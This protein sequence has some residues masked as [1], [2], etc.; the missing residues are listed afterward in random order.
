MN[1]DKPIDFVKGLLRR[2]RYSFTRA[3]A[4]AAVGQ[5]GARLSQTLK[6]LSDQGWVKSFSRG[7]YCAL[8]VQHQGSGLL[9]PKWFID[10]W[11]RF[12]GAEY[13]V[14]ALS[15]AALHGAAHQRPITFQVMANQRLRS[16]KHPGLWPNQK[17]LRRHGSGLQV[18]ILYK[19]H[20]DPG[21]WT[22][23]KS[24]AGY[25]HVSTPEMTAYDVVAY[26]RACPSLDQ[27]ATVMVELGE[28]MRKSK[29][30]A[31]GRPECGTA[32]LQ[33]LGWLLERS[34]WKEKAEG[35]GLAL[36]GRQLAWRPLD[37]SQPADGRRS[38]RWHIIENTD[39]QPDIER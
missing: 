2:G 4:E 13:Y 14:A 27:A 5:S 32:P 35:V 8:D 9:D 7:F 22:A 15:A 3:E 26:R 24:P 23:M 30:M 18:G 31:L 34:G 21:M 38:V 29:L 16:I 25:F 28:A 12:V 1:V 33:R 36:Q 39:V 11:A 19:R 20:I 17:R 6:R 37:S 10:E